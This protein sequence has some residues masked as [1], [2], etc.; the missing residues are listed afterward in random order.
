M[1]TTNINQYVAM[2][3][4]F[5]FLALRKNI[6]SIHISTEMVQSATKV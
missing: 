6:I 4:K 5:I 3:V 1:Q 2:V